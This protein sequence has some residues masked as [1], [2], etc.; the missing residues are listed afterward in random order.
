MELW[1]RGLERQQ[2]NSSFN[3]CSKLDQDLKVL[4]TAK[5]LNASLSIR[6]LHTP[7][8]QTLWT[9]THGRQVLPLKTKGLWNAWELCSEPS[10][11]HGACEPMWAGFFLLSERNIIFTVVFWEKGHLRVTWSSTTNEIECKQTKPLTLE[12]N[13][14]ST[15]QTKKVGLLTN[16]KLYWGKSKRS[17]TRKTHKQGSAK[18]TKN[19]IFCSLRNLATVFQ[20][21]EK[22]ENFHLQV[23]IFIPQFFLHRIWRSVLK[24]LCESAGTNQNKTWNTTVPSKWGKRCVS[25]QQD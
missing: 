5:V 9:G 21:L 11:Q 1:G 19:A 7:H 2:A 14:L 6:E 23:E 25:T 24:M 13:F 20:V 10:H 3:A 18:L 22:K 4:V 16:L 12:I 17:Q 8:T 15:R